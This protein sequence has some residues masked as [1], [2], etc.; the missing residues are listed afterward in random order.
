MK[1]LS[2]VQVEKSNVFESIDWVGITEVQSAI[3]VKNWNIPVRINLGVNLAAN[4]RG[5]HM[6]RLY[7]AQQ[8]Y[9]LNQS[10]SE[11]N[12]SDLLAE[13]I[14]TQNGLSQNAS[15]KLKLSWPLMTTSLRS[16]L[17]G[18]RQYPIQMIFEK[19]MGQF[20]IWIQYEILYSSTCPQSAG[21]SFE[22]NKENKNEKNFAA[23]PHA[24]RSKALIQLQLKNIS[25]ETVDQLILNSEN[26]LGTAVQTVVKKI[27]ELEFAKLNA[28]HL[29]FCEDAVRKMKNFALS[30]EN[31][32][33]FKILC[34]HQ[35]SLHPHNATSL[36]THNYI[37]PYLSSFS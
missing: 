24:Q 17:Q 5:I 31:I 12:V 6:S 13:C 9:L 26:C 27:D 33:G 20:S 21:L 8:Q 18:F 32:V 15:L 10:F 25:A 35:E 22:H 29:M 3:L 14:S 37:N 7:Q 2:D 4:N 34:E 28:A 30:N 1:V 36:L 11:K 23:T 16:E 19:K